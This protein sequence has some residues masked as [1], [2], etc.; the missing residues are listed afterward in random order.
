MLA[1]NVGWVVRAVALDKFHV[2]PP[3]RPR[4]AVYAV[5]QSNC[6]SNHNAALVGYTGLMVLE[7]PHKGLGFLLDHD[8]AVQHIAVL[9]VPR[10]RLYDIRRGRHPCGDICG[11]YL[12]AYVVQ[13]DDVHPCKIGELVFYPPFMVPN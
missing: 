7:K 2:K 3:F 8:R 5:R 4:L 12:G 11:V 10:A 13:H 9:K 6:L 1:E